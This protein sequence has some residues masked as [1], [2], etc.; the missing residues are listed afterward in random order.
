LEPPGHKP[1]VT[2]HE[3][4]KTIQNVIP[5]KQG[6]SINEEK[7]RDTY[8]LKDARI[9]KADPIVKAKSYDSII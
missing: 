8:T 2:E 5:K 4:E 1:F 7:W 9:S 6:F 3:Y